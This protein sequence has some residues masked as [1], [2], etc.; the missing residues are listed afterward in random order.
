[1]MHIHWQAKVS[2]SP[3]ASNPDIDE[4]YRTARSAGALGG[5]IIGAGG[6][7]HLLI[8]T[9]PDRADDVVQALRGADL[10]RIPVQLDRSGLVVGKSDR[11]PCVH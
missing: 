10:N 5:K 4:W 11:E 6:G 2:V 9:A 3:W 8:V 1:L 7:G